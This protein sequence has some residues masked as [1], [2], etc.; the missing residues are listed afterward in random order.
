MSAP[1]GRCLI[2]RVVPFYVPCGQA[3]RH[4]ASGPL[5]T[6]PHCAGAS[7]S[8]AHA[9]RSSKWTCA[10][11][12]ADWCTATNIIQDSHE[13]M[14]IIAHKYS[15][16]S[17]SIHPGR[18]TRLTIVPVDGPPR[19]HTCRDSPTI[20]RLEV[21]CMIHVVETNST[22]SPQYSCFCCNRRSAATTSFRP[23]RLRSRTAPP[24]LDCLRYAQAPSL[25]RGARRSQTA[26][27][28][29]WVRTLRY[30]NRVR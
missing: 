1:L 16:V 28:V 4:P 12:S 26:E 6:P 15:D 18:L 8:G 22:F 30:V 10:S 14:A 21:F 3:W 7:D 23:A 20:R 9:T 19:V 11:F 17:V 27:P 2:L 24:R 29:P 5:A 25:S 13:L